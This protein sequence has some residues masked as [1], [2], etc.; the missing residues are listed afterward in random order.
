MAKHRPPAIY[1]WRHHVEE[2][3][4]LMALGST[5]FELRRK[6]RIFKSAKPADLPVEQ[7][8]QIRVKR[9]MTAK[10]L[11]K[12]LASKSASASARAQAWSAQ[13]RANP[14]D[15]ACPGARCSSPRMAQTLA[16]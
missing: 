11:G 6:P 13:P 10:R 8:P 15:A 4:G 14:L 12:A 9:T 5:I 1:E 2:E 7:A 16:R 3:G